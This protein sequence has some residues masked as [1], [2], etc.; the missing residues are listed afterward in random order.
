TPPPEAGLHRC[1]DAKGWDQILR[2]CRAALA[3]RDWEDNDA[4]ALHNAVG[5]AFFATGDA[6]AAHEAFQSALSLR[7]DTPVLLE[8]RALALDALGQHA[9]AALEM[10]AA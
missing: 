8:N 5:A 10:R 2:V 9:D 3:S 4:A 6:F 7:P 1:T